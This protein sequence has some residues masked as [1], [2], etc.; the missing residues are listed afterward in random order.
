[1]PTPEYFAA[2]Q[3]QPLEALAHEIRKLPWADMARIAQHL[4]EQ[5]EHLLKAER[6][7][8]DGVAQVL[9]ELADEILAD[10]ERQR[11][12]VTKGSSQ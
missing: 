4:A 2:M 9:S 1:M 12:A 6:L 7:D 8:R 11:A 10:A 5:Y 3:R